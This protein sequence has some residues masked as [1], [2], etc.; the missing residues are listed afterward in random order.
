MKALVVDC[1]VVTAWGRGVPACWT[2]LL[3]GRPGFSTIERF[4]TD[5]FQSR[6]AALVPE[7]DAGA[8]ESLAMQMLRPLLERVAGSLPAETPVILATTI[9]EVDLLE[10]HALH[11]SGDPEDS[12]LDRLLA[13]VCGLCGVAAES[14]RLVSAACVSS[15][16]ALAQGAAAIAAGRSDAALVVACD[17]VTEFVYS[18]F[19]SLKALDPDGARPFDRSRRGL[20]VGEAAGYALLMSE[21]RARRESRT[22]LGEIAGWGLSCDAN[23]MT[24]PSR[25]GAGLALA[26]GKAL[27]KAGADRRVIGSISAHGTGTPYNDSMEMKAFRRV[28]GETP[29]PVYSVKG[30]VGHTMGAAGLVEAILALKSIEEA[31]IP[32]S[33]NLREVDSEAAGWVS[34]VPARC[35]G[36]RCVLSTNSGFGGV[37]SALVLRA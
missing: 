10:R 25:D 15:S 23:H 2:G 37:N 24:G 35:E 4:G 16:A 20:T 26:I 14:G 29:T 30:S 9:G 22:R 7:L 34:A 11:G 21:E 13:R 8:Q 18:G 6:V 32:P 19:S 3:S 5:A 33:A 12:R 27:D 28:F 1:D 36:M 31:T 17:A